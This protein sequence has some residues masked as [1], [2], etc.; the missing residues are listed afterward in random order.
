[1]PERSGILAVLILLA[2]PLGAQSAEDVKAAAREVLA[3]RRF[4]TALPGD[5]APA[6]DRWDRRRGGRPGSGGTGS[7]EDSAAGA[8][9]GR[10]RPGRARAERVGGFPGEDDPSGGYRI[11]AGGEIARWVLWAILIAA[12]ALALVWLSRLFLD[13]ARDLRVT[14]PD[15]RAAPGR[16]PAPGPATPL[17]D[18]EALAREG[19]HAEA[20]HALLLHAVARLA[21]LARAPFPAGATARE[22]VRAA[23]GDSGGPLRGLLGL[24]EGVHFG[25]RPASAADYEEGLRRFRE[26]IA[27]ATPAPA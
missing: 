16:A 24:A 10:T 2:A 20:V 21:A 15:P 13:R 19:R 26:W 8:D 14:A 3:N 9:R 6:A 11:P 4:Q 5:D 22:I 25:D 7:D 18:F 17:P 12:A 27:P 23:G 1:M